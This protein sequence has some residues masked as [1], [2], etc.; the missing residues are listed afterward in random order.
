LKWSDAV[1][2]KSGATKAGY[3]LIYSTELPILTETPNGKPPEQIVINGKIVRVTSVTLP[4]L[5]AGQV[6]LHN[7]SKNSACHFLLIPYTWNGS[8]DSTYNYLTEGARSVT[9]GYVD[10][11]KSVIKYSNG[12]TIVPN[13]TQDEFHVNIGND[14]TNKKITVKVFDAIGKLV[15][16]LGGVHRAEYGFVKNIL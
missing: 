11:I 10:N 7:L 14:L 2:P 12:I 4:Q 13:P 6:Q 1:F 15:L 9:I 3:L 5:P 8:T 16:T